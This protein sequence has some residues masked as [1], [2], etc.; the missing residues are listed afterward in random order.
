MED[1]RCSLNSNCS[2]LVTL[3]PHLERSS[4]DDEDS[5]YRLRLTFTLKAENLKN[6]CFSLD[7]L[8]SDS[9]RGSGETLPSEGSSSSTRGVFSFL[10]FGVPVGVLLQLRGS[11]QRLYYIIQKYECT[12]TSNT[13]IPSIYDF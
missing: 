2:Y 10:D 7:I 8:G 3:R 9:R 4:H 11:C 13:N 1:R 12:I 6:F 5:R